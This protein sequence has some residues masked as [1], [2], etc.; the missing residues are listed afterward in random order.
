MKWE[1]YEVWGVDEDG[2]EGLIETTRSLKQAKQIAKDNL[3]ADQV[4]CIIY[5]EDDSGDLVKVEEVVEQA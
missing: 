1:L 3:T 2:Y 4:K 5:K